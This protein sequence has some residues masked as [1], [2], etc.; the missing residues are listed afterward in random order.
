MRWVL[1][2][3]VVSVLAGCSYGPSGSAASGTPAQSGTGASTVEIGLPRPSNLAA[4]EA[5]LGGAGSGGASAPTDKQVDAFYQAMVNYVNS[6]GGLLGKKIK[7]IYFSVDP[8][9]TSSAVPQEMC[10]DFT[11]D[12]HVFAVMD[13]ANTSQ[14]FVSCL[15]KAGTIAF[16]PAGSTQLDDTAL[17]QNSLYATAGSLSLTR[18]AAAEVNGLFKQGF[19]GSGAK[20]GLVGYNSPPFT[21]AISQSLEPALA[22]HGLHLADRQLVAPVTGLSDVA[23]TQQAIG[24]AVLRF[25]NEGINRVLF[26]DIQG[27]TVNPWTQA[28]LA[29]SYFPRLGL[30]TNEM[31]SQQAFLGN[32]R[33]PEQVQE[34]SAALGV[35]WS[36]VTDEVTPPVNPTGQLCDSIMQAAGA[37]AAQAAQFWDTCDELLVFAAG[38]NAGGQLTAADALA[39]LAKAKNLQSAELAAAPDYSGGRRD[40]VGSVRYLSFAQKCQCFQYSSAAVPV[41]SLLTNG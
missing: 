31:P 29:Q 40:G 24:D 21:R 23:P 39:G 15:E 12:N 11:Q 3:A 38:V 18:V 7:P 2:V 4:L 9:K 17:T 14:T 1:P 33:N 30:T 20:I 41:Q 36:P 25:K 6:H 19:F 35:G 8:L 27:G 37:S 26:F 34:Y 16:D 22:A 28:A 5:I 32:G 10:T 13:L